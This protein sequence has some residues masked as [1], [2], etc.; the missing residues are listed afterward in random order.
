MRMIVS[1]VDVNDNMR[2]ANW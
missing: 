2:S 1:D